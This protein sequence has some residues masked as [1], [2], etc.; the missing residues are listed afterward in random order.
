MLEQKEITSPNDVRKLAQSAKIGDRRKWAPT[1][2]RRKG[3]KKEIL[4]GEGA[5]TTGPSYS[6]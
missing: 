1:H 4:G 5:V 6:S 2:D 3:G